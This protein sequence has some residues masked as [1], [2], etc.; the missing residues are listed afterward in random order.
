[1]QRASMTL[2]DKAAKNLE[3]YMFT[4]L[5][6]SVIYAQFTKFLMECST[7][8]SACVLFIFGTTKI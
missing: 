1:M 7:V 3:L 6:L 4:N 5:S 2:K 8:C